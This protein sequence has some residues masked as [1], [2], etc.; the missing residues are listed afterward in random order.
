MWRNMSR[1]PR[2]RTA[3]CL[4]ALLVLLF[5]TRRAAISQDDGGGV[6]I[7]AHTAFGLDCIPDKPQLLCIPDNQSGW[8]AYVQVDD[9]EF[10]AIWSKLIYTDA[11]G[12]EH[13]DI[14]TTPIN[15]DNGNVVLVIMRVG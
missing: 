1:S 6:S 4:L 13:T 15:P 14:A 11:D 7:L 9:S 2:S 10:V 3:L 8:Q 5:A 12:V